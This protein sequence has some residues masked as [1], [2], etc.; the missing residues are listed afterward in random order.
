MLKR[1]AFFT[2]IITL[3]TFT[4]S[5]QDFKAQQRSQEKTIKAAHKQKKITDL[6]Y[7]K[8]MEEQEVIKTTI[9]KYEADGV[10]DPHEKNVIHDKLDRAK[11]RLQRYKTNS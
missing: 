7:E 4:V 3:C 10:L 6:E 11:K 5:A 2:L 1:I 9:E 8:L